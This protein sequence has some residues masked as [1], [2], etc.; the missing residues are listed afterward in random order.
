MQPFGAVGSERVW[1]PLA[2]L[3]AFLSRRN[4]LIR[5][6]LQHILIGDQHF[7]EK[8]ISSLEADELASQR[9]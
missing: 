1:G 3:C 4:F 7:G 8:V 2:L 6:F 5:L 9:T